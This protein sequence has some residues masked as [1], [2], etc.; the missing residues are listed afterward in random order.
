MTRRTWILETSTKGTGANMV[1][2]ERALKDPEVPA[3]A[4]ARPAKPRRRGGRGP[5]EGRESGRRA[6]QRVERTATPLPAGHVRK[7]S[8]GEIGKVQSLDPRAGT[9]TVRWLKGGS[10]STVRISAL[11]RR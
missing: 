3:E 6:P 10:V 4:P 5:S 11:S 8:T 1:P 7:R 9:A 2:L